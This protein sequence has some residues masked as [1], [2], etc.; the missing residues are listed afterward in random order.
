MYPTE[1]VN[2]LRKFWPKACF[3]CET[4][5][6]T[7]NM[8]NYKGYE[9]QPRCNAHYPTQS[10]TTAAGSPEKQQSELQSQVRCPVPAPAPAS[11]PGS[12][13]IY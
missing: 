3:H 8:K 4:C 1:K 10:F 6:V 12:L 9:K 11:C 7:L 5:K 2:C 13:L